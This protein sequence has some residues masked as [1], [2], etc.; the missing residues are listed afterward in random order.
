[1][2]G[3]FPVPNEVVETTLANALAAGCEKLGLF[4]MV[5]LSGQTPAIAMRT[6]GYCRHLV[7]RFGADRR[8]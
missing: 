6:V 7:E 3:K 8:L 4:F 1:M 2:N 5:G